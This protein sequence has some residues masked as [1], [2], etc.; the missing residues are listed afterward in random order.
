M[1]RRLHLNKRV[2]AGEK[3]VEL[4]GFGMLESRKKSKRRN[5][6]EKEEC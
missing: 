5:G 3:D 6:S 4:D 1:S 2:R